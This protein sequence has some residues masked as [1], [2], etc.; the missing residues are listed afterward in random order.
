MVDVRAVE[1][2]KRPVTLSEIKASAA[3]SNM[4]L[5]RVSR[6]AVVPV[7][8]AEWDIVVAMSREG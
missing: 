1:K 4:A 7:T 6:L 2:L 3:L 8:D 5:V